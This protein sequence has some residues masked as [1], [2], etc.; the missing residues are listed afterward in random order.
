MLHEAE[1]GDVILVYKLDRLTRSVRDLDELLRKFEKYSI[2]FQSATEQFETT[3]A[4]G[5]L[6]MRI[7]AEI[8]QWEREL[9]AERSAMGKRQRVASGEWGGGPI[10]FGYTAVPSG[11]VKRGKPLLQLVPDPQHAHIVQAIFERY[12]SGRGMRSICVWLNDEMAVQTS[13]K[14]RWRVTSLVRVLTNPIYCGDVIHGRRTKGP[15]TRVP[16]THE[17]LVSREMFERV[18]EIFAMRK[19]MAPR[20]AT[21]QYPMAG[22]ARCGVCGGRIDALKRRHGYVYRCSNYVNGIGCGEETQKPLTSASGRV[23]EAN[24]MEVISHL[25]NPDELNRF[26]ETC[27]EESA[28][29]IGLTEA[30][31]GRLESDLAESRNAIKRWDRAY[32]TGDLEWG[33]YLERVRPHKDRMRTIEERLDAIKKAPEPPSRTELAPFL[34]DFSVAWEHLQP[35]ERKVLLQR[36]VRAFHVGILIFPDRRVELRPLVVH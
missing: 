2:M 11:K 8:A 13:R 14:A 33:E 27:E 31:I 9:I 4:S 12:L 26:F 17:P 24:L 21:G 28:A 1:P 23:V 36:F 5:R 34:M 15:L 18:Q 29:T 19:E 22:I 3:T 10:P 20:Q 32:E 30:E 35:E 16:G 6:F 25:Q 7:V